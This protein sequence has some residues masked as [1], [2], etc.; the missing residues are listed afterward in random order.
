M[1]AK[2]IFDYRKLRT[3]ANGKLIGGSI[4]HQIY[5]D[6]LA[7][8]HANEINKFL[9]KY[10]N[11]MRGDVTKILRF[12]EDQYKNLMPEHWTAIK[13]NI[14][15][16]LDSYQNGFLAAKTKSINSL[17][18]YGSL[19]A[20]WQAHALSSALPDGINIPIFVPQK[21][22]IDR[23]MSTVPLQDAT[24]DK[25]WSRLAVSAK[26]KVNNAIKAGVIEGK[27]I[28]EVAKAV[29]SAAKVNRNHAITLAKTGMSHVTN[30]ARMMLY[31]GN[32]DVVKGW[33]FIAT[34]DGRTTPLCMDND[35]NIYSVGE[36]LS[37]MPPL[38]HR[39]R[40]TTAPVL[41]SWKEM[42]LDI[43]STSASQRAALGGPVEGKVKYSKWIKTEPLKTKVEAFGKKTGLELHKGR[44][45]FKEAIRR[46]K[47][48]PGFGDGRVGAYAKALQGIK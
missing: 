19:E 31:E 44:I 16:Y 27:S 12:Y 25:H 30:N 6:T 23:I 37:E 7:A 41:K 22:S 28:R 13:K 38:H 1:M 15:P 2:G 10:T 9:T 42:G 4:R 17:K 11:A 3:T 8:K 20:Q 45:S 48:D 29:G 43:K 26:R 18:K 47:K 32:Q 24:F 46:T 5:L 36:G 40:S 39:C 14:K 35:G 21:A 34:L 33:K